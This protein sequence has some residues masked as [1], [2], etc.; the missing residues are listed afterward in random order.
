MAMMDTIIQFI[1]GMFGGVDKLFAIHPSDQERAIHCLNLA[2]YNSVTLE[3]FTKLC[4]DYLCNSGCNKAH[5]DQQVDR[6][7]KANFNPYNKTSC[8][9]CWLISYEKC[10]DI[11]VFSGERSLN[12]KEVINIVDGRKGTN[13]I[14][15]HINFYVSAVY[16]DVNQQISFQQ[17]NS[18]FTRDN[19]AKPYKKPY[20]D[21][22]VFELNEFYIVAR[23]VRHLKYVDSKKVEFHEVAYDSINRI[24]KLH[25]I[26][27]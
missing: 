4:T 11:S 8:H 7:K 12:L 19:F 17:R 6:L 9:T 3:Q 20:A 26:C 24:N 14:K 25:G 18:E 16:F 13:A 1:P 5:I 22:I 15:D 10:V 21:L 23:K 27:I 2:F